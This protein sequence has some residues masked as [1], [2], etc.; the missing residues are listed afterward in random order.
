[1]AL[2]IEPRH[3]V[4]AIAVIGAWRAD[5]LARGTPP[6]RHLRRGSPQGVELGGVA[7]A[8]ICKFGGM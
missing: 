5:G 1:V 2:R 7:H 6:Q 8:S 4:R 3:G